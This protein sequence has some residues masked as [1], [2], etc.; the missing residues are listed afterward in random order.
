MFNIRQHLSANYLWLHYLTRF[1]AK[2][3]YHLKLILKCTHF[4]KPSTRQRS[5][6]TRLGHYKLKRKIQTWSKASVFLTNWKSISYKTQNRPNPPLSSNAW[7]LKFQQEISLT[8][9]ETMPVEWVANLSESLMNA[10]QVSSIRDLFRIQA[11]HLYM[12]AAMFQRAP[13]P[14]QTLWCQ[15]LK[16]SNRKKKAITKSLLI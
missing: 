8:A 3:C 16:P 10:H 15:S 2:T 13:L 11:K 9:Q 4:C 12:P 6:K 7:Y 14:D 1:R 5:A